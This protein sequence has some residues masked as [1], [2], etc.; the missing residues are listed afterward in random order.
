MYCDRCGD[1]AQA[2]KAELVRQREKTLADLAMANSQVDY[3]KTRADER[4][5]Q[6]TASNSQVE[7]MRKV[8]EVAQ[9]WKRRERWPYLNPV[10]LAAALDVY[11]A[12]K[13]AHTPDP[14]NTGFSKAKCLTCGQWYDKHDAED[15]EK[16]GSESPKCRRCS[17][18]GDRL[19]KPCDECRDRAHHGLTGE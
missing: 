4:A 7:A 3:W 8:V 16:Q 11:E 10:A 12:P 15:A 1:Q 9:E 2:E 14:K 17:W 5:R 13:C 6:L 18:V 19:Y